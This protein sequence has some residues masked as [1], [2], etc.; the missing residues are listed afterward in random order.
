[1]ASAA[2]PGMVVRAQGWGEV[3]E[4]NRHIDALL[5]IARQLGRVLTGLVGEARGAWRR[6]ACGG[7]PMLA[8]MRRSSASD[9][10]VMSL[11]SPLER[12]DQ[13]GV[14]P[15]S[16]ERKL[17]ECRRREPGYGAVACERRGRGISGI[18]RPNYRGTEV[19][20][21]SWNFRTRR[22]PKTPAIEESETSLSICLSTYDL[23]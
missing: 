13:P 19:G 6:A 2:E 18:F 10:R 3:A 4:P 21:M 15:S 7:M 5:P 12:I 20:P 8:L 11:P 23:R 17:V 14:T 1:M 22:R 16:A 9:R